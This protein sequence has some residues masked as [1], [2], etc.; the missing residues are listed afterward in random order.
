MTISL[1]CSMPA[2]TIGAAFLPSPK[3]SSIPKPL[4]PK[5]PACN[6]QPNPPP[7]PTPKDLINPKRPRAQLPRLQSET[8]SR[9][10]ILRERL[11]IYPEFLPQESFLSPGVR[12]KAKLFSLNGG[13]AV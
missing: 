11:A 8:E 10:F 2:S 1:V 3:T 12:A 13:N 9:G 7:H 4:G 6:P 5:S